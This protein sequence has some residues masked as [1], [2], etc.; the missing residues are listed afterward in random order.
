MSPISSRACTSRGSRESIRKTISTLSQVL[1]FAEV[2]PDPTAGVR[3]PERKHQAVQPPT[4]DHIE[5]VLAAI[6]KTYRL[7][8]IVLDATGQRVSE[9]TSLTWGDLDEQEGRWRVTA[10]TAKTRTARWVPVPERVFQAV[11]ELV[12]REDRDLEATVFGDLTDA[13]LRTAIARA[14]RAT[15]TPLFSPHDVRHR[16]ASLWHLAGVPAVQAAAWLG[17]SPVEHLRTY[18][19]SARPARARHRK[20]ARP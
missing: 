18:A 14:C 9:L 5:A 7:P 10:A 12:P 16:R 8:L 6:G 4:A 3:L 20:A 11:C 17:H 19:R 1:D 2:S 15:G 13:R